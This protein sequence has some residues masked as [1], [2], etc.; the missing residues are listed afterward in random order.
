MT[1][2]TCCIC[3]E[4]E[5]S[6]DGLKWITT[7]CNHNFHQECLDKWYTNIRDY[8]YHQ[9]V[10]SCP[11]CRQINYDDREFE[12]KYSLFNLF[13]NIFVRAA[14]KFSAVKI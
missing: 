6:N 12:K 1:E 10:V 3:L 2:K 8:H 5:N 11:L 14:Y 4:E 7:S 9:G 13:G